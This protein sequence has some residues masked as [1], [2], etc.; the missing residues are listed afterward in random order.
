MVVDEKLATSSRLLASV[1]AAM[2]D[3]DM[4]DMEDYQTHPFIRLHVSIYYVK[5]RAVPT[6]KV[7]YANKKAT[8]ISPKQ[9]HPQH[10]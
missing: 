2:G 6:M 3:A 5:R 7:P 10:N 8:K 4:R 9:L 1:T